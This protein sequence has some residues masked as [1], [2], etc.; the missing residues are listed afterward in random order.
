MKGKTGKNMIY[1]IDN[2]KHYEEGI[3][4]AE[5]CFLN[6]NNIKEYHLESGNVFC[7]KISSS[8]TLLFV[9]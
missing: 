6:I 1:T 8:K 9:S 5:P 4:D 3:R 7:S 2:N